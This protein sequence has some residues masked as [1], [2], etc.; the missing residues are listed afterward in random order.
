MAHK[1]GASSHSKAKTL[2]RI[3]ETIKTDRRSL[4]AEISSYNTFTEENICLTENDGVNL[5][6]NEV[7]TQHTGQSIVRHD[8]NFAQAMFNFIK[9]FLGVGVI[10]IAACVKR[11]GIGNAGICLLFTSSLSILGTNLTISAREKLLRDDYEN[12]DYA[13][14]KTLDSVNIPRDAQSQR[15][16]EGEDIEEDRQDQSFRT[17]P[18]L[19]NFFNTTQLI[20]HNNYL[21]S[22]AEMG[23]RCFGDFGYCFCT[24]L[25]AVSQL[26]VITAYM[27]FFDE[28]FKSYA[29]LAAL[30][31]TCMFMDLKSISF[32]STI[33]I[34]LIVHS[35]FLILGVSISDIP[36]QNW[37]N[38]TYLEYFEFPLFFGAAIY[39]F[40]GDMVC[41][42]IQD[43]MKRPQD[44]KVLS[45]ICLIFITF[46][47]I[48]V[49][50][51]PYLAY[52]DDISS[53]IINSISIEAVR[54][55]L[56]VAYTAG[57]GLSCPL[58]VYPLCEI[59]YR[60]VILDPYVSLFKNRPMSKFYICAVASLCFGFVFSK[61]IPGIESFINISGGIIGP[62]STIIVPVAFYWKAYGSDIPK[63][64]LAIYIIICLV[65]GIMGFIS[66]V[67]T[68]IDEI[69]TH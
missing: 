14:R 18:N 35:L 56:K 10:T 39:M 23:Q 32:F 17:L 41:M 63:Y 38:I 43:S 16:L 47:C 31:P 62:P 11:A 65:T 26:I 48:V 66:F 61:V 36:D 20:L 4:P 49:C 37:E 9:S 12:E 15:N 1:S 40:E 53:P 42:N 13:G 67:A 52:G 50:Y 59:C 60:S 24:I 57:V 68:I 30:I 7:N 54:D 29:M 27:K 8:S 55:Y 22:Y 5:S 44:F 51:V 45:F 33:S 58:M 46:M 28:Y 19:D 25:L 34:F 69:D 21:K 6:F 2:K 3:T 64:E